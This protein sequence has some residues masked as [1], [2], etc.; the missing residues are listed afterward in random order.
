[1]LD[2][3]LLRGDLDQVAQRLA[4]RGFTLDTAQL[5]SLESKRRELQ[6]HTEQLQSERNSRS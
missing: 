2:P 1:M 4:K 3:K 6:T 5:E